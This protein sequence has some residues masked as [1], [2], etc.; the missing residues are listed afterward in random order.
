MDEGPPPPACPLR[1]GPDADRLAKLEAERDTLRRE[2][3]EARAEASRARREALEEAAEH[4]EAGYTD[5]HPDCRKYAVVFA[6]VVRAIAERRVPGVIT[7]PA[8]ERG[9][10]RVHRTDD[11]RITLCGANCS[12]W[13][14]DGFHGTWAEAVC[15]N[16]ACGS[17]VRTLAA[18]KGREEKSK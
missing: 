14:T 10:P 15:G 13:P 18:R 6:G 7:R 17:C 8:D 2:L 4:L 3:E 1:I 5:A 9:L 12:D 11:W 16:N